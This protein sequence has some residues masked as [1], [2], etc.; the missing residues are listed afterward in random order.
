MKSC[1]LY[2][3]CLITLQVALNAGSV[4]VQL[5]DSRENAINK[6]QFYF[7]HKGSQP[8]GA[9][10]RG[11]VKV[12][13]LGRMMRIGNHVSPANHRLYYSGNVF[14]VKVVADG[15]KPY[16]WTQAWPVGGS[17]SM[18]FITI[19][20]QRPSRYESPDTVDKAPGADK[21]HIEI[22]FLFAGDR[23]RDSTDKV[24]DQLRSKGYVILSKNYRH[25]D[26][27]RYAITYHPSMAEEAALIHAEIYKTG[28]FKMNPKSSFPRNKISIA[29]K[30]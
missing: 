8:N 20:L 23:Y 11:P 3:L 25:A 12:E 22:E 1:L 15:F 19:T 18:K 7:R 24:A 4:N 5:V 17:D 27:R 14:E 16:V 9:F 28:R 29:L 13:S 10:Q 21:S 2:S 30:P 6:A 26:V